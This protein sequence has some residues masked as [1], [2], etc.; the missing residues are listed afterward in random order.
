MTAHIVMGW[1]HSYIQY[2][3][4]KRVIAMNGQEAALI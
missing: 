2:R 1:N 3:E 4:I